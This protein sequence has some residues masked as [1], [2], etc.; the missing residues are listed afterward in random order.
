M[1]RGK[2]VGRENQ[3]DPQRKHRDRSLAPLDFREG[4][5]C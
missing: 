2:V 1:G 3:C 5:C 4:R